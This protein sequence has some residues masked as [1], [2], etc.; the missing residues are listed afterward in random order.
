MDLMLVFTFLTS[1]LVCKIIVNFTS[2]LLYYYMN[3]FKLMEK[4][5]K[6][7][8]ALTLICVCDV[9]LQQRSTIFLEA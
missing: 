8:Q 1:C 9:A 5:L 4:P 3:T 6:Q 7:P 2:K